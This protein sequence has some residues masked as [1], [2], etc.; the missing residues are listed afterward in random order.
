MEAL[1]RCV[2]IPACRQAGIADEFLIR[3]IE[4]GLRRF[5]IL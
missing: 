1:H 5:E 4:W 2:G 3:P